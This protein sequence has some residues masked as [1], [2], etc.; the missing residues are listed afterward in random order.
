MAT[1]APSAASAIAVAPPRPDA[2]PVT[3]AVNPSICIA[4]LPFSDRR[5][6]RGLFR[7]AAQ[8]RRAIA[9]R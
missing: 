3:I 6:S 7:P 9:A 8:Q 4:E 1:F 5:V 2:P